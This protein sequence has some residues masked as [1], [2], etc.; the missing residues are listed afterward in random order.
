M[1]IELPKGHQYSAGT[2]FSTPQSISKKPIE[3]YYLNEWI[4]ITLHVAG[5][6]TSSNILILPSQFWQIWFASCWLHCSKCRILVL[7]RYTFEYF[8]PKYFRDSVL[9]GKQSIT[10]DYKIKIRWQILHSD[11]YK[12]VCFFYKYALPP[13][14]QNI[15]WWSSD[16]TPS[17]NLFV[18]N[19]V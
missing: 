8:Q 9:K 19:S 11:E 12:Q 14:E 2:S 3:V 6:P 7:L 18:T 4:I 13:N 16:I 5:F 1:L 10:M 17:T 15:L